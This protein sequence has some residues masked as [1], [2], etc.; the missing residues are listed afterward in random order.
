MAGI[1]LVLVEEADASYDWNAGEETLI[2]HAPNSALSNPN[3]VFPPTDLR[4]S[5]PINGDDFG[6]L[7]PGVSPTVALETD[8]GLVADL[9]ANG[10]FQF[11]NWGSVADSAAIATINQDGTAVT[12]LAIAWE[13][14]RIAGYVDHYEVDVRDASRSQPYETVANTTS[15]ESLFAPAIVGDLYDI[16]VRA[17]SSRGVPSAFAEVF[18]H[19][20][21]GKDTAPEDVRNFSAVQNGNVVTF[22][23]AQVSDADLSGYE[24]RFAAQSGNPTWTD[25]V[26]VTS[27]TKGTLVTNAAIPPG[28]WT[29]FVK[30]IDTSGNV[31]VNAAETDIVVSN[32]AITVVASQQG[33]RWPG[34]LTNGYKHGVSGRIYPLGQNLASSYGFELFDQMVPDAVAEMTY[35][36]PELDIGKDAAIRLYAPLQAALGPGHAGVAD[37]ILTADHR[38]A[39]GAYDGFENWSVGVVTAR[40]AKFRATIDTSTGVAYLSGMDVTADAEQ[41]TERGED[42][43]IGIGGTTVSFA[44]AF[45]TVPNVQVT[46]DSTSAL[47]PAK[48]NVTATGFDVTVFNSAGTDVG[49]TVDWTAIGV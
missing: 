25:G 32:T 20:A 48:S 4:V 46:V 49:G 23:W 35:D 41:R 43:V 1:N 5:S 16:R 26:V 9:A 29:V 44:E 2:D 6:F 33:G 27:V 30:A 42:A 24:I 10:G 8:W 17:I 15:T 36:A 28:S 47:L 39:A 22:R 18:G 40:F 34:V 37:P 7:D 38:T 13:P 12:R 11:L 21:G 14:S 19:L 3:T 45:I 31:S